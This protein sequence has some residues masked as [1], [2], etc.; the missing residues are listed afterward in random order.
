METPKDIPVYADIYECT[1]TS[2]DLII[3]YINE[4]ELNE[5]NVWNQVQQHLKDLNPKYGTR[6]IV[7][8][9]SLDPDSIR[10]PDNTHAV[11][12]GFNPSKLQSI[13][14]AIPV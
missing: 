3:E 10:L 5:P 9:A 14:D 4:S 8:G 1:L 13:V 11:S 6:L 12:I 2:P 7:V